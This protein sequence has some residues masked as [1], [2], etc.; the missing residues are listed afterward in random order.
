MKCAI[1]LLWYTLGCVLYAACLLYLVLYRTLV[2]NDPFYVACLSSSI[3]FMMHACIWFQF[4]SLGSPLASHQID[5]ER[6]SV[7]FSFIFFSSSSTALCRMPVAA[8]LSF[9]NKWKKFHGKMYVPFSS[10][11]TLFYLCRS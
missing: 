7:F 3:A 4:N 11:F 5:A 2:A 1:A 9:V 6:R 10:L 8:C